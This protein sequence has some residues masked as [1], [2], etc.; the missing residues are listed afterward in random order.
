MR[1]TTMH[2]VHNRYVVLD[3]LEGTVNIV[4]TRKAKKR[5]WKL[6]ESAWRKRKFWADSG[7][8]WDTDKLY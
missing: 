2:F 5:V 1:R 7:T 6:E 4:G 3:K 8:F